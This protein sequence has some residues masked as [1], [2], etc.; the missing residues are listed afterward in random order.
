MKP[1]GEERMWPGTAPV[2]RRAV[3][4]A[5]SAC[6]ALICLNL[7]PGEV[8]D[9]TQGHFLSNT[10][11]FRL[12]R[13][14]IIVTMTEQEAINLATLHE[15]LAAKEAECKDLRKVLHELR[16]HAQILQ[17]KLAV[18]EFKYEDLLT[19]VVRTVQLDPGRFRD[20]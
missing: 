12:G 19:E 17:N 15:Q 11:H 10:E 14:S 16:G 8:F 5:R 20:S 3:E 9:D 7:L 18:A 1:D 4:S 2:F 13:R 6:P